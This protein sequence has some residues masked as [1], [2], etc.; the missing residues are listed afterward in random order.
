[1]MEITSIRI[2]KNH[3]NY[4]ILGVA[5]IQLDNCLVI[6]DI[7]IINNNG[8]R[9]LSFPNRKTKRY[10]YENGEY[11]EQD[12]YAD[13]VHPSN[14]EFRQ[15]LESEIFKVYDSDIREEKVDE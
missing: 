12:T 14:S 6:H 10:V 1:M 5:S 3:N 15:Y 9:L 8:K 4:S 13:I 11:S 7:K 2:K